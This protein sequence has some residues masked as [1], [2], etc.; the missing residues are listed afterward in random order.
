V[1][2][3][4]D[5]VCKLKKSLSRWKQTPREWYKKLDRY[6]LEKGFSRSTTNHCIYYK[7]S[8]HF[9]MWKPEMKLS[10]YKSFKPEMKLQTKNETFKPEMKLQTRNET[11]KPEMK[12][13]RF[14][15]GM[16][17]QMWKPEMKLLI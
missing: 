7:A 1:V 3:C 14:F 8:M 9:Q 4:E 16:H 15:R 12:L 13:Q 10:N 6:V 17:F 2:G 11:F 5:L